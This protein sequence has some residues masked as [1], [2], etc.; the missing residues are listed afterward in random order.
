MVVTALSCVNRVSSSPLLIGLFEPV[1]SE[2]VV[3]VDSG[4][5]NI[6]I[7]WRSRSATLQPELGPVQVM[8]TSECPTGI[9]PPLTQ[10]FTVAPDEGNSVN[11]RRLGK[12]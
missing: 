1:Q 6:V 8:V 11:A 7:T 4:A 2:F 5:D 10:V 9:V 12:F 3:S